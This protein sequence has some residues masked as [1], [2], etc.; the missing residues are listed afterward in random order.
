MPGLCDSSLT[1][2]A[3]AA[4]VGLTATQEG[5]SPGGKRANQL[6]VHSLVHI[7]K[8]RRATGARP[9]LRRLARAPALPIETG[10]EER[11]PPCA[12]VSGLG[13]ESSS[14]VRVSAAPQAAPSLLFP[15]RRSLG[16]GS[17][18]CR[19]CPGTNTSRKVQTV[20]FYLNCFV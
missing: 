5:R 16:Q 19:T 8:E 18:P 17:H 14:D 10:G 20:I 4:A 2:M 7:S 15:E 1:C 3:T 12:A 11:G 9:Q 13:S 6:S